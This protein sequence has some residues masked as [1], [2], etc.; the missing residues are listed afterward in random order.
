MA[1][2]ELF[3]K[4]LQN[5]G[6]SLSS[7]LSKSLVDTNYENVTFPD[8]RFTVPASTYRVTEKLS[9]V[10]YGESNYE[11]VSLPESCVS[12]S[13]WQNSSTKPPSISN[14]C[15]GDIS[16]SNINLK[17]KPLVSRTPSFAKPQLP[18]KSVHAKIQNSLDSKV[19]KLDYLSDQLDKNIKKNPSNIPDKHPNFSKPMIKPKP[20]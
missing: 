14:Q 8:K 12:K 15:L 5:H 16:A 2:S 17:E 6:I 7:N 11:N 9:E 18:Q 1:I 3:T 4:Y 20:R 10:K 13:N 19:K